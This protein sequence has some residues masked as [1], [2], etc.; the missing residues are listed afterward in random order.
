[1]NIPAMCGRCHAESSEVV[2]THKEISQH[3][4]LDNYF[5]S[6]HGEAIFRKGLLVS[7]TCTSCHAAHDVYPHEDQRSSIHRNNIAKTCM[8]CHVNIEK[9][10]AKVVRGRLW[11][12]A[13]TGILA[14]YRSEM[15]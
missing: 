15:R 3:N 7:A 13:Q 12:T 10:H 6:V 9:V 5:M 8:Q 4:V 2:K 1:M 11:E 14:I